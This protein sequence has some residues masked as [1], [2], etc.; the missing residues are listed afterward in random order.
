MMDVRSQVEA[1][2]RRTGSRT[3]DAGEAASVFLGQTYETSLRDLWDACTKA[4]R[5]PEWFSPVNGELRRNGRYEI[6]GNAA[7]TIQACD[8]PNSFAA[9]WEFGGSESWIEVRFTAEGAEGSRITIEHIA[10][11]DEHWDQFGPG[12][13]GI[14]WDLA[15]MGL[16]R[17]LDTGRPADPQAGEDWMQ[18]A[19]G[20]RFMELSG[21]RWLEA[22]V[23]AGTDP[24]AARARAER[25]IAFYTGAP[26]GMDR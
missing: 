25:T 18:S 15:V 1:V 13:A 7:G 20:K 6:E 2:E 11:P 19:E 12:A 23:A 8:P 3:V 24:D 26:G 4:E 22:D 10:M 17:Y 5:L 16:A 14:G 21:Q 9:T